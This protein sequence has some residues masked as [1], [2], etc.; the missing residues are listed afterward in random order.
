MAYMDPNSPLEK[1]LLQ[2]LSCEK[3]GVSVYR[4][5]VKAARSSDLR[6]QWQS[7]M[8]QTEGHVLLLSDLCN[9][10]E[11]DFSDSVL[12]GLYDYTH[13]AHSVLAIDRAMYAHDPA[14]VELVACRAVLEIESMD[15]WFW[16][17]IGASALNASGYIGRELRRAFSMV[18]EEED[19]HLFQCE[20]R[21]RG[22]WSEY[23]AIKAS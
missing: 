18:E 1:L 9:K 22:L 7:H 12:T 13:G 14:F 20:R 6:A 4:N 8:M 5:A 2:T 17:L 10:L 23:L 21:F 19:L 16:R 3:T 11:C 15:N